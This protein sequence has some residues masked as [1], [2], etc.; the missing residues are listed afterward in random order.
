MTNKDILASQDH[1]AALLAL[2]EIAQNLAAELDI[3]TLLDNIV[4]SAV[5]V[6]QASAGSLLIWD[7]LT[8]DLVFAVVKGGGGESLIGIR[9]P[10]Y[11]GIAGWVLTNQRSAIV[12][13]VHQDPR[14]FGAIDE[15]LGHYT[16]SLLAVPLHAK[17]EAIGVLEVLN[18]ISQ[19]PF[20]QQDAD[21]LMALA[22]QAAVAIKNARLYRQVQEERDR[23]VAL[24]EQVR[25][26]LASEL[27]DVPAQM[28]SAI[29]MHLGFI[30]DMIMDDPVQAVNEI[31]TVR[32]T[33]SSA[34]QQIRS[35]IFELRPVI[36]HTRGL[37]AALRTYVNRMRKE[38][39]SIDIHAE[40][41]DWQERLPAKTEE[42][43]FAIV[44]EAMTNIE[45]HAE[46]NKMWLQ[47]IRQDDCLIITIRDNGKGFTVSRLE[48]LEAQG[49]HL[50]L[51]NMY[52]RAEMI[53]GELTIR[54][55][56]GWGTRVKLTI[57]LSDLRATE[58]HQ[59]TGITA[60]LGNYEKRETPA[61]GTA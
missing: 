57:P 9:M 17:G 18:K 28:L 48:I 6:V 20:D 23:I 31:A 50:G 1:I 36:L 55:H 25:N 27:H 13:N 21:L 45:K 38:V 49:G 19:E 5:K 43:C 52:E 2:Q 53:G 24:E 60:H 34:L 29:I 16:S 14:F 37:I 30:E 51:L 59:T 44:R 58:R 22:G 10:A 61:D 35:M 32:K 8:N 33:A 15:S 39:N 4:E 47:V 54:S 3:E 42:I 40:L 56:P 12:S 7:P 41:E 46:A 11:K 26:N